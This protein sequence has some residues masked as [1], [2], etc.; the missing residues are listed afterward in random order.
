MAGET[1]TKSELVVRWALGLLCLALE[2]VIVSIVIA[3]VSRSTD[4]DELFFW[5]PV[6]MTIGVILFLSHGTSLSFPIRSSGA[7][8]HPPTCW[9]C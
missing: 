1:M 3:A 6:L 4:T 7:M 8:L 9:P 2:V 5:H